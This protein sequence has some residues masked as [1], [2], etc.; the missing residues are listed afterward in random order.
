MVIAVVVGL[1]ECNVD[2]ATTLDERG[3]DVLTGSKTEF[4]CRSCSRGPLA[5]CVTYVAVAP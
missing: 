1:A 5:V 2:A 4:G 3:V